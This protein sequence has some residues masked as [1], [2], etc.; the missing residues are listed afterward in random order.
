[1]PQFEIKQEESKEIAK[2]TFD[3]KED[4]IVIT[5]N[6]DDLKRNHLVHKLHG[7]AL[8]AK[9]LATQVKDAKLDEREVE[10]TVIKEPKN[11]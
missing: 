7:N 3:K 1:M 9:K 4:Y 5:L 10:N 11:K 8:I 2:A 6:N